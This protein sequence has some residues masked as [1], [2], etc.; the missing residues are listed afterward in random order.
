MDCGV[1]F[2]TPT[3]FNPLKNPFSRLFEESYLIT[4]TLF[5][6]MTGRR[7]SLHEI[8]CDMYDC[9][10]VT[11]WISDEDIFMLPLYFGTTN[12]HPANL[13]GDLCN[14]KMDIVH[15]Q[16]FRCLSANE[17][18]V[19]EENTVQD[20]SK[21]FTSR[22]VQIF[23]D[24]SNSFKNTQSLQKFDKTSTQKEIFLCAFYAFLE[25]YMN[26]LTQ[27]LYE[28][29]GL[30]VLPYYAKVWKTLIE[31]LNEI[32]KELQEKFSHESQEQFA[33]LFKLG[34]KH[35]K[36]IWFHDDLIPRLVKQIY[37]DSMTGIGV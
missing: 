30:D 5:R 32:V 35:W 37:T 24:M 20:Y 31:G 26:N 11:T 2:P 36:K 16:F 17:L 21:K 15:N 33:R 3:D 7:M 4:K 34:I 13:S 22:V 29:K 14:W 8:L 23:E 12:N 18:N 28:L 10:P 9:D 27:G 25:S 1:H 19:W 6:K